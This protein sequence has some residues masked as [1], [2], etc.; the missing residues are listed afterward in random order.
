MTIANVPWRTPVPPYV[1]YRVLMVGRTVIW[2]VA[3]YWRHRYRDISIT[4]RLC[5]QQYVESFRCRSCECKW[6]IRSSKISKFQSCGKYQNF[7]IIDS[8]QNHSSRTTCTH[9]QKWLSI[10]MG[11]NKAISTRHPDRKNSLFLIPALVL[12][13][14]CICSTCLDQSFP[15]FDLIYRT[16]NASL[17]KTG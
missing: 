16:Y 10:S 1:E 11:F 7:W 3:D 2:Q 12:I 13:G 5:T 9:L 4:W 15:K 8:F 17:N 14:I 6:V